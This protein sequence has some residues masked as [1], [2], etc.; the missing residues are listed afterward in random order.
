[1]VGMNNDESVQGYLCD[2]QRYQ[3]IRDSSDSSESEHECRVVEMWE[4][5]YA[6][7]DAECYCCKEHEH[8]TD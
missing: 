3:D 8:L 5:C 7:T 2:P 6:K 4:I 1:M